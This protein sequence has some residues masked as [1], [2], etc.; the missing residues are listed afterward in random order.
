[1]I[2]SG[3]NKRC[4][5]Q[6]RNFLPVIERSFRDFRFPSSFTVRDLKTLSVS[7]VSKEKL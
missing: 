7:M 3:F 4:V 2:P 1:L 6:Y 5:H